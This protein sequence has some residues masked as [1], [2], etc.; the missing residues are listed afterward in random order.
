MKTLMFLLGLCLTVQAEVVTNWEGGF[1]VD[2]P[3]YWLRADLGSDG[4]ML[5]SDEVK[6]QVEPYSGITL[7]NQVERLRELAKEEKYRF[8]SERSFALNQTPAHELIYSRKGKYIIYYVL[9]A[10][11]RGFLWTVTSDT[12][13]SEAFLEGQQI[14]ESFNVLPR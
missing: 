6:M 9:M 12:T 4:L 5:N 3:D 13:D 14:I 8:R 11:D 10:G 7:D 1:E 2:I